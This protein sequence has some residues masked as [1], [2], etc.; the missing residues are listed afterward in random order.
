M[1]NRAMLH[2]IL[3]PRLQLSS[4]DCTSS[5]SFLPVNPDP[6]IDMI[7]LVCL[8]CL[9]EAE[10]YINYIISSAGMQE[11]RQDESLGCLMDSAVS[12]FLA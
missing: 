5:K 11:H 2:G 7:E 1:S 4:E 10:V 8:T 3:M 6:C 9:D 12:S